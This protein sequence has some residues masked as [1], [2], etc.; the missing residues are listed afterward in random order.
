METNLQF[1]FSFTTVA[2]KVTVYACIIYCHLII[3]I[4]FYMPDLVLF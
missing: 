2:L 1:K 3:P 4:I